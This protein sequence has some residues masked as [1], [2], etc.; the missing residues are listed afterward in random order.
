MTKVYIVMQIL[1]SLG[2]DFGPDVHGVF[3]SE[4]K[5]IE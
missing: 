4:E 1:N 2:K 3:D 5:A